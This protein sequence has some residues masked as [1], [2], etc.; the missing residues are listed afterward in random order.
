MEGQSSQ[1]TVEFPE[2]EGVVNPLQRL[3]RR[4]VVALGLLL[5]NSLVVWL[6]RSGYADDVDVDVTFLDAL[7]YSGVSLSTTGYGDITPITDSARL[8]NFVLVTPLRAAFIVVVVGT[9]IETLTSGSRHQIRLNRWRKKLRDHIVVIGY[10]VKGRSA[11]STLLLHGTSREEFVIVDPD[12]ASVTDANENGLVAILGDAT[13]AEVLKR[14]AVTDARRIIVTTARDDAAILAT[15]TARQL[16]PDVPISVAVRDLDNVPL[17]RQGGAT[18]V[19]TSSDAAGRIL[20]LTSISPALG[21]VLED[22]I[23]YGEGLEVAERDV[24]PREEGKTPRQ[25][26][27][28]VLAVVRDGT[29]LPYHSPAVGHLIRD[30]RIVVVRP[31]E[32]MPWSSAGAPTT[33]RAAGEGSR[34]SGVEPEDPADQPPGI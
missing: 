25:V 31:A 6:G 13:R 28:L 33:T 34:T 2:P 26:T 23:A 32:T 27:D 17:A 1:S 20:G 29:V 14:A 8:L 4:L 21:S 7:Y 16:N 19:I 10:G 15:L 9:T 3:R 24:K 18:Q 11:V 30:D 22:L 12:P 5:A